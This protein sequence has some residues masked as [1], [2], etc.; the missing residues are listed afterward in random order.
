M[1]L[2]NWTSR[3]EGDAYQQIVTRI[4]LT[5]GKVLYSTTPLQELQEWLDEN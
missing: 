2:D 4:A 1:E 5:D 3:Y